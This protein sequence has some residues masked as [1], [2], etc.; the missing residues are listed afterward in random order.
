[1]ARQSSI[2][3]T[4]AS[5]LFLSVLSLSAQ[6]ARSS[7]QL[8]DLLPAIDG[9]WLSGGEA[10]LSSATFDHPAVILFTF[11]RNGGQQAQG[12]RQHL[13][14][15]APGLTIYQVMFLEAVP[16]AFRSV[17]LAGIKRGTPPDQQSHTLLLYRDADA[18]KQRLLI[19]DVDNVC[20]L[21]LGPDA[22]IRWMTTGA[23]SAQ[24]N[25]ELRARLQTMEMGSPRHSTENGK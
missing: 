13:L 22:R 25:Q 17:T 19:R 11:S 23:L 15:D 10:A 6:Q 21:L 2:A 9:H 1:M 5:A 16:S 3:V 7:L 24:S 14:E 20:L 12:W 4:S 18:W 8:G